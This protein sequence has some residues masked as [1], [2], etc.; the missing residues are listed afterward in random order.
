MADGFLKQ[1]VERVQDRTQSRDGPF[2]SREQAVTG[3]QV[4]NYMISLE[5]RGSGTNTVCLLSDR[6]IEVTQ[7]YSKLSGRLDRGN[8]MHILSA[9]LYLRVEVFGNGIT[10]CSNW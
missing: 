1:D 2:I 8:T 10:M 7:P 9:S 6:H 5:S 3:A 4:L